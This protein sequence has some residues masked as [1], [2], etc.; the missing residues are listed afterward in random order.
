MMLQLSEENSTQKETPES[1]WTN[2]NIQAFRA[3]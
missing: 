3:N 1:I 2:A